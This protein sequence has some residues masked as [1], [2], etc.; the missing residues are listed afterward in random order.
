MPPYI[1]S[2]I[3][4]SRVDKYSTI[5]VDQNRYSVPDHLVGR[6]VTTLVY[7]EY[8]ECF[9]ENEKVAIHPKKYGNHEWNFC[10]SHYTKTLSRK[11]G[12]VSNSLALKQSDERL[13]KICKKYYSTNPKGF[14]ALLEYISE[15]GEEKVYDAIN[16]LLTL[17]PIDIST[18]KIKIICERST[19]EH[20]CKGDQKII[21][22]SLENIKRINDLYG[23]KATQYQEEVVL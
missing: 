5:S 11:P 17:S 2:R 15:V 13:Q 8:I 18:D 6:F 10:I 3:T 1:A 22:F 23:I 19:N 12:A 20:L 21:D 4:E 16:A 9:F 14:I 7:P